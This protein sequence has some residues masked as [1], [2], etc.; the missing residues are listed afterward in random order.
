MLKRRKM[1][2][3]RKSAG[4]DFSDSFKNFSLFN[5]WHW[6]AGLAGFIIMVSSVLD[7]VLILGEFSCRPLV[8][9][10]PQPFLSSP[11]QGLI[12]VVDVTSWFSFSSA[13]ENKGMGFTA[14]TTGGRWQWVQRIEIL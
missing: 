2:R 3:Q 9:Q 7:G 13:F 10:N 12:S 1:D 8:L 4:W 11:K 5:T 14:S 6:A